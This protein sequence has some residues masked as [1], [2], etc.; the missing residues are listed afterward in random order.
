MAKNP[1]SRPLIVSHSLEQTSKLFTKLTTVISA[2]S[3]PNLD[4]LTERIKGLEHML[5]T[6]DISHRQQIEA[7]NFYFKEERDIMK[8]EIEI[9]FKKKQEK[10]VEK[11]RSEVKNLRE[12]VAD[13]EHEG[14]VKLMDKERFDQVVV[15]LGE[16]EQVIKEKS[17]LN[18]HLKT[19]LVSKEAEIKD[20]HKTIRN[21]HRAMER[22]S[23]R[24][25]SRFETRKKEKQSLLGKK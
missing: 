18:D 3:T 22:S 20:M 10:L 23:L 25:L 9:L 8:G 2:Q 24:E 17:E 4:Q 7:L 1:Q 11:Y 5:E 15:R 13:L 6:K 21:Y 19:Q 14:K 16:K 12:K